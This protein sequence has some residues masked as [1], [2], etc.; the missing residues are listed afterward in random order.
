MS[1]DF[2]KYR[3]KREKVLGVRRRGLSFGMIATIVS[4]VIVVG[5]GGVVIPKTIT[6]F[7]TRHL[8]D[9]I[10]KLADSG[11]WD[12]QVVAEISKLPGVRSAQTD[13]HDTRLVI[14]FDRH[15]SGPEKFGVLF[16]REG[17]EAE[18]LN[19]MGHRERKVILE[20]EAALEAS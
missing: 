2:E 4:A 15:E 13:N 19:R 5:L 1:Y 9:A 17:V 12:N 18:L 3:G 8:D 6:Y 10:Y 14:T 20:K 7:T 11:R 16:T